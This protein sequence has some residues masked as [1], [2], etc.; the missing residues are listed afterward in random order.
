MRR[1]WI[2]DSLCEASGMTTRWGVANRAVRSLAERPVDDF[3]FP[4]WH[5]E[6]PGV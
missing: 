1:L 4:A 6:I 5:V 3:A 2:P